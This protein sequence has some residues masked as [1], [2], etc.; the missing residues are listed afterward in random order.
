VTTKPLP[1]EFSDLQDLADHW[2]LPTELER[3]RKR[4]SSSMS[5]LRTFYDALVPRAEAILEHMR[6][7]EAGGKPKSI[8]DES[9][10]LIYLLF[11]LAEVGQAIEVHG[12]PE[13]VNGFQAE[14]WVPEHET[15]VW[16]ALE[17]RLRPTLA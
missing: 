8:P 9:R 5:E 14:R 15:A 7:L 10:N 17:Q 3:Q 11:S 12:Q 6:L 16:R 1:Q 4:L 2:S 13:V